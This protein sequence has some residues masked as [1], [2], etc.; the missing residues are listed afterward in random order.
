MT[1]EEILSLYLEVYKQQRLPGSPPGEQGLM[2][3]VCLPLR[4][5]RGGKKR[6]CQV[7]LQGPDP[8]MYGPQG[9]EPLGKGRP[10]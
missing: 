7:L 5:T 4:T 1:K 8:L 10:Q 9:A 2:E 3:E 6:R